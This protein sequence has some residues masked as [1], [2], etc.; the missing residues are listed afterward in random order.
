MVC[1]AVPSLLA[2]QDRAIPQ[3]QANCYHLPGLC[4]NGL[5]QQNS[6]RLG[7]RGGGHDSAAL[8]PMTETAIG[9]CMPSHLTLQ[10]VGKALFPCWTPC[11]CMSQ[12]TS[13]ILGKVFRLSLSGLVWVTFV[14]PNRI[15]G[16]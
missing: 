5:V 1:Q 7:A 2:V 9:L 4:G 13:K 8:R 12:G 15:P 10:A 16:M 6:S 3:G 14:R 11:P